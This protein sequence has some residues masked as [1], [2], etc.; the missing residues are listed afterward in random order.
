[1]SALSSQSGYTIT[2]EQRPSWWPAVVAILA[3][4]VFS[5]L[6]M[7]LLV[8]MLS[9]SMDVA[10][11][12]RQI[13]ALAV[14]AK[15]TEDTLTRL[16]SDVAAIRAGLPPA[17]GAPGGVA[18]LAAMQS[19]LDELTTKID[20]LTKMS[21]SQA[22]GPAGAASPG[23]TELAQRIAS[24]ESK[25]AAMSD[26]ITKLA[27]DRQS[28]KAGLEM[29]IMQQAALRDQVTQMTSSPGAMAATP[30]ATG[31]ISEGEQQRMREFERELREMQEVV[32]TL[33]INT[34]VSPG[35]MPQAQRV[36]P[37]FDSAPTLSPVPSQPPAPSSNLAPSTAPSSDTSRSIAPATGIS[38]TDP[39]A[40]VATSVAPSS[41][42]I[43]SP[44]FAPSYTQQVNTSGSP[45]PAPAIFPAPGN[46]EAIATSQII[47]TDGSGN[48]MR[49]PASSLRSVQQT[50]S[51][52]SI[53][54]AVD[55]LPVGVRDMR[56][57]RSI[58]N[59][60]P[61]TIGTAMPTTTAAMTPAPVSAFD[62]Y[63]PTPQ[64]LP[65]SEPALA[66]NTIT[67]P[68]TLSPADR[69]MVFNGAGSDSSVPT[70]ASTPL[71]APLPADR[72]VKPTSVGLNWAQSRIGWLGWPFDAAGNLV[73]W[74]GE[75]LDS[76]FTGT[77]F[78]SP[79]EWETL[80]GK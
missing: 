48:V 29:L 33:R 38:I 27:A 58:T 71:P 17:S 69:E 16:T 63:D 15:S 50:P 72:R 61:L 13:D 31:A 57:R 43:Q 51:G 5:A 66:M 23:A 20:A 39:S 36:A 49:V 62:P 79:A 10:P 6:I 9:G 74:I 28:G 78:V 32:R 45:S 42:S 1:M 14:Q 54:P 67:S 40:P 7:Y 25:F 60:Q 77:E 68:Y 30:A 55:Y 11:V 2:T 8:M 22:A 52:S 76:A 64:T 26:A 70:P 53:R 3:A 65:A 19:R 56:P 35:V 12:R 46:A 24:I 21:T 75:G 18:G 73:I 34:A 44:I 37:A 47:T 59:G 80:G 41:T 4:V